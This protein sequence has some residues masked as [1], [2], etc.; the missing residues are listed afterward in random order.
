MDKALDGREYLVE[1]FSIADAALFYVEFWGA[2]RL[3]VTLPPNCASHYARMKA[4]P[5]V[6]KALQDEG[7]ATE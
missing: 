2:D 7:I 3:H 1:T 4:R 5:A 6:Q